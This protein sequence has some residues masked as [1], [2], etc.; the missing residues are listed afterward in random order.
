[1]AMFVWHILYFRVF[2]GDIFGGVYTVITGLQIAMGIVYLII[3]VALVI[4]VMLQESKS[5]GA[6]VIT[7][8]GSESFYG[9]N[10]STTK[11]AFLSKLTILL[12]VLF[13]LAAIAFTVLI[14]LG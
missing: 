13:A 11:K 14:S 1:M 9:K 4:V 2:N 5:D 7:G 6:S 3:C 8:Q 12:G 10:K